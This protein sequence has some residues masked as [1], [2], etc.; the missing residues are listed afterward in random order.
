MIQFFKKNKVK[1]SS[2]L[3][4]VD[5]HS[6]L[7]PQ[8]DDGVQSIE[9]AID[10]ILELVGMGYEKVITTPHIMSDFFNNSEE[11]IL[12]GLEVVRQEIKRRDINMAIEAAAE[13]YLDEKL[14]E[15]SDNPEE[16]FLTFGENFL[17]FETSFMNKPFYLNDFIFKIKSRGITP[18][19]AHPE[20]YA[21]LQSDYDLVDDLIHRGV[22]MQVNINSLEGYYSKEVKKLAEKL[23]D[24]RKVHFLG[25][26]CHNKKHINVS[27]NAI[28]RKYFQ[29]AVSLP[30]LN[31]TLI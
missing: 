21:Y 11:K 27:K 16:E 28:Q 25:S 29:K 6:H 14:Y 30:L 2:G 23:I 24:Q 22:L 26:D 9:E 19:M 10:I 1:S 31:N 20:R 17:L 13:Y 5:I 8:L 3:I 15:R 12:A 18:V 4:K 7:I